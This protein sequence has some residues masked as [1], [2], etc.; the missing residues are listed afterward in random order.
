MNLRDYLP[1]N[2]LQVGT[3]YTEVRIVPFFGNDFITTQT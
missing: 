2:W 3:K 1:K